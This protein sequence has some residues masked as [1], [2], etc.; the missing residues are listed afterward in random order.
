MTSWRAAELGRPQTF[1]ALEITD[2]GG[3]LLE[4]A[5]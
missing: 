5:A 2:R 4:A 1:A 3:R